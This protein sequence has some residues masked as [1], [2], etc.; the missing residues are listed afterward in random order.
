MKSLNLFSLTRTTISSNYLFLFLFALLFAGCGPSP[1]NQTLP[2]PTV[3][4]Q[5][6]DITVG[7]T[8]YVPAYTKIYSSPRGQTLDLTVTLS[9]HNTDTNNAIVI[10]AVRYYDAQGTLV[11]D[12]LSAPVQLRPLGTT[13]FYVDTEAI[14]AGAAGLGANFI[15]EWGAEQPV[16]EPIVEAIMIHADSTQGI[17]FTSPGRVISQLQSEQPEGE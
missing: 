6:L 11:K 13:D 9:I 1:T 10:T 17:S 16:Y 7:Q 5:D 12:Y 15:V 3:P 14:A 2:E 4:I 8:I